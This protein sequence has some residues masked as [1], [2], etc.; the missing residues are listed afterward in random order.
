MG[1]NGLYFWRIDYQDK[2]NRLANNTCEMVWDP[3]AGTGSPSGIFTHVLYHN[4]GWPAGYCFDVRCSDD[5]IMDD[6]RLENYN[7]DWK[8]AGLV[9]YLHERASHYN[10]NE[11]LVTIGG[12]FNY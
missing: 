8:A 2:I 4:Y 6:P 1:F 10:T 9:S 12:D 7:A 5:P 3:T 11:L